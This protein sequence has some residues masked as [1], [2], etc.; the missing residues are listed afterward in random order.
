MKA[1]NTAFTKCLDV[2]SLVKNWNNVG[3][4]VNRA[5]LCKHTQRKYLI[6]IDSTLTPACQPVTPSVWIVLL[7]RFDSKIFVSDSKGLHD[8]TNTTLPN[9]YMEILYYRGGQPAAR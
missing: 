5:P 8:S 6:L 3:H 9:H 4:H 2:C 1:K 7:T